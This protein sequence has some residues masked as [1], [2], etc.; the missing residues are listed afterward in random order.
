MKISLS[1][2][3]PFRA[4]RASWLCPLFFKGIIMKFIGTIQNSVFVLPFEQ[5]RQYKALLASLEGKTTEMEIKRASKPKSYEQVKTWWGLFAAIVKSEFDDRGW[6]TSYFFNLDQPT[7]IGIST[8][9]LKEYMYAV[10]PVYSDGK[11]TTISKM[12]MPQLHK[13][14]N[15]CRDYAATQWGIVTPEPKE[16]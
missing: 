15:D 4:G 14:F 7:G 3:F 1:D 11:R 9:L 16:R 6:D 12:D 10:C 13:F 8:D 5:A 2:L